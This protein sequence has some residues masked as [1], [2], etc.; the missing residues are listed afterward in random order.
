MK[1]FNIYHSLGLLFISINLISVQF[2]LLPDFIEGFCVG[3]GIVLVFIG[4][5][6]YN[7]DISKFRNNKIN[8]LKRCL[9]KR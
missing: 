4:M 9:G 7:H 1:K 6:A 5:Y 3:I 2:T 8:F